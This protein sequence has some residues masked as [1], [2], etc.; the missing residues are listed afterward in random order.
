MEPETDDVPNELLREHREFRL[1][2]FCELG[3]VG[4]RV[5]IEAARVDHLLEVP[6]IMV[7]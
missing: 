7:F 4:L 6:Y 1:E 3:E 5:F 2:C